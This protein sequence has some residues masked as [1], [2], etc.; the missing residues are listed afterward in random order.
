MRQEAINESWDLFDWQGLQELG[1]DRPETTFG[2]LKTLSCTHQFY[3]AGIGAVR[4]ATMEA[5][6][7]GRE[8]MSRQLMVLYGPREVM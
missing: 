8:D 7:R 6:L 1:A 2:A 3:L 4:T 5:N